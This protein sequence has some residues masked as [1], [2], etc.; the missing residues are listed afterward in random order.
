MLELHNEK[1]VETIILLSA[2][3]YFLIQFWQTNFWTRESKPFSR[4][5]LSI[6]SIYHI[7]VTAFIN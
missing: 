5:T 2:D 3:N 6:F 4:K 7:K 1:H